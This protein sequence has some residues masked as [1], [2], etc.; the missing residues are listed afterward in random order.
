MNVI[1]D[2][3][4]VWPI[5]PNRKDRITEFPRLPDSTDKLW[6]GRIVT[7]TEHP[8]TTGALVSEDDFAAGRSA[9]PYRQASSVGKYRRLPFSKL[10]LPWRSPEVLGRALCKET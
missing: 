7:L 9:A 2:R 6:S 3:S 10:L 5:A 1:P 8:V 4:G